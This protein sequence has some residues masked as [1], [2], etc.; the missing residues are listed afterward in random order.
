MDTLRLQV[1]L[2]GID[3]ATAPLQGILKGTGNLSRAVKEARDRLKE[4]N[5]ANKQLESFRSTT[6]RCSPRSRG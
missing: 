2:D 1:I 3:R 6:T 4:L 5:T